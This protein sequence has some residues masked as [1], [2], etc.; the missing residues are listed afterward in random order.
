MHKASTNILFKKKKV[1]KCFVLDFLVQDMKKLIWRFIFNDA[2][3]S[4]GSLC[5]A[6]Q[7]MYRLDMAWILFQGFLYNN[8]LRKVFKGSML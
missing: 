1:A 3:P 5:W 6:D 4:C 7:N 8:Y 2:W